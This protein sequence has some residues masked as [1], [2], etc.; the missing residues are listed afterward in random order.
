MPSP[1]AP[2][3]HASWDYLILT[4][5]NDRQ[6]STY[7]AQLSVRERVGQLPDV[8]TVMVVADPQGH[9][10]G[11]GCSTLF[12]LMQVLAREL[13]R[14]PV[15]RPDW[16]A[17][18]QILRRLRI[19]IIHA[20]GDSRRVPAYGPCGKIF[21]PV[22]GEATGP[23]IAT[24]FDRLFPL[25]RDLPAGRAGAGQVA[26]TAGDA[27]MRFDPATVRL[28]RPG[29]V[30]LGAYATPEAASKHGVFCVGG[31]GDVRLFLQKPSPA[32][33]ARYGA[34]NPNGK[35]ILDIA[36]MSF[37]AASAVTMFRAFDVTPGA[38]GPAFS[39]AMEQLVLQRGLDLYREI[40]CAL[41]SEATAEH[42]RN[43]AVA[44]GS[45]WPAE[46]LANAHA[47]LSKVPLG[48]QVLPQCTFLHFGTTRQLVTSGLE[49][50]Q[51]DLG[52]GVPDACLSINNRC[53]DGGRIEGVQ[54][55]V[56]GC[57]LAAPLRLAGQNVVVGVDVDSPLELPRGGCLDVIAGKTHG[58]RPAWFVRCYDI[59][60]TFKDTLECGGTFLGR[61][62]REW[63]DAVGAAPQQVWDPAIAPAARSLWDAK[64]FP[65]TD[66]AAGYRD[67]LWMFD[68]AQAGPAQKLAFLAAERY[69]VA[70]IAVLADLE[71]FYQRRTQ[72][73]TREKS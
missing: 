2:M 53:V 27:L 18:E 1:A 41:G 5:S 32:D 73:R 38:K 19:L 63:L 50:L 52:A 35:T 15:E 13:E 44:S 30:A 14:T 25:F 69:S 34:I 11:S 47:A 36:V 43:S 65:A 28:D 56:E 10:V 66:A 60:D 67:W 3:L 22:P 17:M 59:G 61:P 37:D 57:H 33:Q 51:Y 21:S 12:C 40:S 26:V 62:M 7:E 70:E 48:V 42:H 64:V 39:P 49:L 6:A 54:C 45:T 4:A 68:P 23:L 58:G 71:A 16:P 29:I 46:L 8:G 9:R 55:W 72:L 31:D 20:G 24:L